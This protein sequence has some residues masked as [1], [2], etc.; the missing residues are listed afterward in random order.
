M[1]TT[2]TNE[3]KMGIAVQHKKNLE[4]SLYNL[5]LSLIEESAVTSPNT[6]VVSSLNLQISEL[7]KKVTAINN[8]IAELTD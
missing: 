8:E 4:Y 5:E 7:S 1:T 3:E 2:L 6:E